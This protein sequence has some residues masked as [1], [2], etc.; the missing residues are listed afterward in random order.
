MEGMENTEARKGRASATVVGGALWLAPASSLKHQASS[1]LADASGRNVARL[2]PGLNDVSGLAPGV[3]FVRGASS[4][5][6]LAI[7]R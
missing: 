5:T 6:R 3:Y 7:V 2:R 1:I 4:V